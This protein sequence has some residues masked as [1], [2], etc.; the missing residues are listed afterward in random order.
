MLLA[1]NDPWGNPQRNLFLICSQLRVSRL[2]SIHLAA[3]LQP[4]TPRLVR[5][6]GGC[7][8]CREA[9][10]ILGRKRQVSGTV[11]WNIIGMIMT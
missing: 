2:L 4:Q 6:T 9:D 11:S 1:K 8:A 7:N 5:D 10:H 3:Q